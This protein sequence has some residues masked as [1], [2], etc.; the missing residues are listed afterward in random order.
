MKH[1]FEP[2]VAMTGVLALMAGLLVGCGQKAESQAAAQPAAQPVQAAAVQ[3]LGGEMAA[4][5]AGRFVMGDEKGDAD[6][7]PVHEVA[8][9]A[10][11]M[12]KTEVTQKSY[13]TLMG[14]NPATFKG[15]D[16]PVGTVA[17]VDAIQYCNRR[18]TKEGLTPCYDTTKG[19]CNFDADG[20]RL[21][22]EAEWEYACRAGTT[23]RFYFGDQAAN[24]DGNGWYKNNAGKTTHPVR[25]KEPN[26]WG[27]YDMYGN[28]AEWC[29]DFYGEKY[30]KEKAADNPHGP[31][32][33][34]NRVMRGGSGELSADSC[35]SAARKEN[36]PVIGDTCLGAEWYGF[37]C[38]R[39]PSAK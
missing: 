27:L 19:T 20:Y 33:G 28:A 17:W 21:P 18:S 6:E 36:S 15:D 5:P 14:K 31:T 34:I 37:R 16:L 39:T 29:Q 25:Q 9:A 35:R 12:D 30:Y 26:A 7:K 2:I 11:L 23:T 13:K 1:V 32:A 22:T 24:L 8:V 4:I 38:V 10:F 3:T